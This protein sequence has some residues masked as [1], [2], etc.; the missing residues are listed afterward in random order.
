MILIVLLENYKYLVWDYLHKIILPNEP[1]LVCVWVVLSF[2]GYGAIT[3]YPLL[4]SCEWPDLLGN[5]ISLPFESG[6]PF[7]S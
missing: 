2:P 4:S 1:E 5:L 7:P 3:S 6:F